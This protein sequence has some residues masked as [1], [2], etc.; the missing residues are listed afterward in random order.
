M[1]DSGYRLRRLFNPD[2][3][4][5]LDIAVDHGFFGQGGFLAGIEDLPAA[6]SVL[7]QA[8]PDAIQ[9]TPGQARLL[10]SQGGRR[11]PALVMRTDVANVYG[12][13]LPDHLF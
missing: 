9:L 8:D 2:S 10:Q 11:R 3:G 1:S 6:V 7:V 5:C 4:R 12:T 13:V